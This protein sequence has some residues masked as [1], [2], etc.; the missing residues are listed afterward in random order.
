MPINELQ[1]DYRLQLNVSLFS[2]DIQVCVGL[3][4][5]QY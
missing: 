1:N 2:E 5:P 3:P 4:L